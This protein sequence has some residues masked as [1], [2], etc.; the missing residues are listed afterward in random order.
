MCRRP[1]NNALQDVHCSVSNVCV[2]LGV[3][4]WSMSFNFSEFLFATV[5]AAAHVCG[6]LHF[7]PLYQEIAAAIQP[8]RPHYLAPT[9]VNVQFPCGSQCVQ[10]WVGASCHISHI[11]LQDMHL[12]WGAIPRQ[13]SF[14]CCLLITGCNLHCCFHSNRC[15]PL[16]FCSVCVPCSRFCAGSPSLVLQRLLAGPVVLRTLLL[17]C[18]VCPNRLT[19][20]HRS[21]STAT[22]I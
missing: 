11:C 2:G 9:A 21:A 6:P 10:V 4:F 14:P 1:A 7:R 22:D 18:I 5:L 20:L 12:R 17:A 3:V 15:V 13:Q 19:P 8:T 16:L